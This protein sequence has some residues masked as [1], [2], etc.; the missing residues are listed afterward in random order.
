MD[1][2]E[3]NYERGFL[4]EEVSLFANLLFEQ[5]GADVITL[6]VECHGIKYTLQLKVT[7]I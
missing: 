7:K 5:T 2:Q 3:W 6:P 1:T 4:E